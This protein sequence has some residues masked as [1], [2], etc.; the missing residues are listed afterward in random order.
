MVPVLKKHSKDY[1]NGSRHKQSSED[2][3]LYF[4]PKC[5]LSVFIKPSFAEPVYDPAFANSAD[6]DQLA[7]DLDL[8]CLSLSM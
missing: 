3:N 6:T 8:H 2:N 5:I 7:F 4:A 1:T